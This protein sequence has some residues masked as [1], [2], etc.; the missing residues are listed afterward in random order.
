MGR[1]RGFLI[2]FLV[3]VGLLGSGHGEQQPPETAAQRCFCQVRGMRGGAAGPGTPGCAL[4]CA[5]RARAGGAQEMC[6]FLHPYGRSPLCFCSLAGA[7]SSAALLGWC[8]Q[9]PHPK[10]LNRCQGA[11]PRF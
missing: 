4:R 2:G 3:A 7:G 10:T 1:R 8:E 6:L 5:P 11:L 9:V